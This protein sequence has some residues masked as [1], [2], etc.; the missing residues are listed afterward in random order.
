MYLFPMLQL[1][2]TGSSVYTVQSGAQ[3]VSYSTSA[4]AAPRNIDTLSLSDL[5]PNTNYTCVVIYED[6]DVKKVYSD[7]A[8]FCTDYS[9]RKCA[10]R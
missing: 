5:H 2:C 10:Q 9:G 7:S 3:H 1:V 4:Q 8:H 6:H